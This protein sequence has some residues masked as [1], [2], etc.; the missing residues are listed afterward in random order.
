MREG[1]GHGVSSARATAV[2]WST[3]AFGWLRTAVIGPRSMLSE[4]TAVFSLRGQIRGCPA[5]GPELFSFYFCFFIPHCN[6]VCR[7]A[8]HRCGV[9][10]VT[11]SQYCGSRVLLVTR[12]A[13]VYGAVSLAFLPTVF[14]S[15]LR[16]TVNG[17]RVRP[18]RPFPYCTAEQFCYCSVFDGSSTVAL[19]M[20][21]CIALP[22]VPQLPGRSALWGRGRRLLC[23]PDLTGRHALDR[24][25]RVFH[26][27]TASVRQQ[28]RPN[29][30]VTARFCP[31]T[32]FPTAGIHFCN[33]FCNHPSVPTPPPQGHPCAWAFSIFHC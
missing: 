19:V 22:Y 9:G 10:S 21:R 4:G 32:V 8:R 13:A 18:S 24:S 2:G 3:T 12:D 30:F 28:R 33:H 20:Q 25:D 23:R 15:D 11:R 27:A 17:I 7:V 6:A 14:P 16:C 31:P 29:R 5:D 1:E 26:L